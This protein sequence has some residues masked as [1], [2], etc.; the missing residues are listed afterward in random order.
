MAEDDWF[1]MLADDLD[2]K[3]TAWQSHDSFWETVLT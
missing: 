3:V 2:G 1:G